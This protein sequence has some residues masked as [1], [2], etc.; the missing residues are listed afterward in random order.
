MS[1]SRLEVQQNL[2]STRAVTDNSK[3][4]RIRA[5]ACTL[6]NMGHRSL[7]TAGVLVRVMWYDQS[8]CKI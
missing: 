1:A 3:V 4:E 8:T 5:H 7:V 6:L 2:M